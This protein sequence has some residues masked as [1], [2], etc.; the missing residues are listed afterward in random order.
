MPFPEAATRPMA[1]VLTVWVAA[2]VAGLL[3]SELGK[4]ERRARAFKTAASAGFVALALVLGALQGAAFA[5]AVLAGLVLSAIGDVALAF[6]GDRPFMA[7]LVAFLFGHVAYI[8]AAAARLPVTEW[9]SAWSL[10]PLAVSA[11][12]TAWLWPHLGSMRI[13][14]LA[15]VSAITL[16]VIGALAVFAREGGPALTLALGALLFYASDLSVARDRFVK[17]G[18]VNKAWGLPAYYAGQVLFAWSLS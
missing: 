17:P 18:F 11:A 16:M 2:N 5:R 1:V 8:F 6:P 9:P 7:G 3:R 15:Y 14:V 12:A 10:L 13:P 4:D